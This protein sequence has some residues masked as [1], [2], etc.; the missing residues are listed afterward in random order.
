MRV[1]DHRLCQDDGTP[2]PFMATPHM[3]GAIEPQYLVIHATSTALNAEQVLRWLVSPEA[4]SSAHLL[5]SR[6]GR[7]TQLVPFD[8]AAWHAGRSE[9]RGLGG[10]NNH[11]IAIEL[12]NAGK[13]SRDEKGRFVGAPPG[14][15]FPEA[16][17]LIAQHRSE[18][19]PAPWHRYTDAQL[20]AAREAAAAVVQAYGLE[21]VLGHDDIAPGRKVDPGP[22]FPM[23]EFRAALL[24]V[25]A[26]PPAGSRAAKLEARD[27]PTP[28]QAVT[29]EQLAAEY[30]LAASTRDIVARAMALAAAAAPPLPLTTG[31][32]LICLAERGRDSG[33]PEWAADWLR[34]RLGE[35]YQKLRDEYFRAVRIRD[36]DTSGADAAAAEPTPGVRSVLLAARDLAERTTGDAV[37]HARHLGAALI[38]DPRGAQGSAALAVLRRVGMEPPVLRESLFEFVTGYDDDHAWARALLGDEVERHS[39][40][41]FNADATGG[42][43]HLGI[44]PDVRA[45]AALIAARTLAPPLSIGLFGEWGSGKTF[46][47][48]KLRD[49]VARLAR[50]AR[51]S[52]AMQRAL[53]F[54]KRIVQIEFN[55]WHYSEGNL[56][57]SLV[58][59]IFE[60]LRVL[61]ERRKPASE[62]LQ[63]PLLRQLGVEKAAEARAERE[64][65]DAEVERRAAD[66]SLRAARL[67]FERKAKALA[68]VSGENILADVPTEDVRREVAGALQ[69]LGFTAVATDARQLHGA[70]LDARALLTRGSAVLAPLNDPARRDREWSHLLL[71]L[72]A[73]PV[74][75]LVAGGVLLAVGAEGIATVGALAAGLAGLLERGTRWLKRN[76][77]IV[78]GWLDVV[79]SAHR[80]LDA[81]I[82]RAQE[83]N[84][85]RVR[86]AEELL[87]LREADYAAARRREEEARSRV[88]QAEARLREA[89]VTR[90]LNTFIEERANSTDYRK[91]LGVLALVRNDFE[92]LSDLIEEENWRLSPPLDG[93]D[94]ARWTTGRFETLEDEAAEEG[95]RINRIVLYIDDLDRCPPAK[96]V[97][98]LQ[99]VHLLLAFPLF[100][101][102]VGVDAR[103]VTRSLETRYRDTLRTTPP[104]EATARGNGSPG[105]LDAGLDADDEFR[106]VFGTATSH[107][108][109]EKI[110]QVPF[111]LRPMN[112]F[113]T[114]KMVSALLRPDSAPLVERVAIGPAAPAPA[115]GAGS[116]GNGVP[117]A[118]SGLGGADLTAGSPPGTAHSHDSGS[119]DAQ[120]ADD[121]QDAPAEPAGADSLAI[122]GPEL[123][124]IQELAPLL[125][126]SPRALKR[127]V[128]VYRLVKV[129]LSR[130]QR[131][132]FLRDGE[133]LA[134]YQAV[135]LLLALDTGAPIVARELFAALQQDGGEAIQPAQSLQALL[136]GLA[137]RRHLQHHPEWDRVGR[138]V[139]A[140][141]GRFGPAAVR[142]LERSVGRVSRF[143]FHSSRA[144]LDAPPRVREFVTP[145]PRSA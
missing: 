71:V 93:D 41:A 91:H 42:R 102:V 25:R 31:L 83:E 10:L 19:E 67:R 60:N 118:V 77:G 123:A 143:S 85:V 23:E 127:F 136:D 56:W 138:W 40:S 27:V 78:R 69:A 106:E 63:E 134:E 105:P 35:S 110:F 88:A 128:N 115:A 86:E 66:R 144:Q 94:D 141:G 68:K 65:D 54:Y 43:D 39:P 133:D 124:F 36:D 55:A 95:R 61:D 135:L 101:V 121:A 99:A 22:A 90:L 80:D 37:A 1:I 52:N 24:G 33:S 58:Q 116:G 5:V 29:A 130:R 113:A 8:R 17:V 82:A 59:H 2:V 104:R 45:F 131:E 103:W 109:L 120:G 79:E 76:T 38:T 32:L 70:L 28:G 15:E 81:R 96:V 13:L 11:S 73:G 92:R 112:E 3:G 51:E 53:P 72:L 57:A 111:W 34:L 139:R 6:E 84:A 117:D 30:G 4:R 108:Y 129:R 122:T 46:F 125:G 145:A 21:E 64:R 132:M 87:R 49:E 142:R 75:A 114:R 89:S 20:R 119:G 47:M 14:R 9:W 50:E 74:A 126:R 18:S 98:V 137:Q 48:R 107:D 100:V 97:E 26:K 16:D 12:E 7:I 140:H 62:Q 44:E